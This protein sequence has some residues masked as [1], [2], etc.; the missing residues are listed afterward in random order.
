MNMP[1]D[2]GWADWFPV[3]F[4][5]A[6]AASAACSYVKPAHARVVARCKQSELRDAVRRALR[7]FLKISVSHKGKW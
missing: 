6:Y 4:D 2:Q 5:G 7:P 1:N 3:V